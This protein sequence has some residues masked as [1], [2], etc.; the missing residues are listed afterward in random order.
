MEAV[1]S[2]INY[3]LS[4]GMLSDADIDHLYKEGFVGREVYYRKKDYSIDNEGNDEPLSG[5]EVNQD[6]IEETINKE[7]KD[8]KTCKSGGKSISSEMKVKEIDSVLAGLIPTWEKEL[9]PITDL[10]LR[11]DKKA[12]YLSAPIILKKH[13]VIAKYRFNE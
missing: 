13:D 10:A 5:E 12:N 9:A 7:I 6:I 11:F 3:F 4:R 1:T 8:V 2:L